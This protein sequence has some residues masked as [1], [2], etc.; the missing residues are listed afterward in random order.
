MELQYEGGAPALEWLQ[1]ILAMKLADQ[2]PYSPVGWSKCGGCGFRD[3]CWQ[4]AE[5]APDVALVYG[6]DQGLARALRDNGARTINELLTTFDQGRLSEFRRPVGRRLQRVGRAAEGILRM[7]Q[8]LISGQEN[9]FGRPDV[10]ECANYVMFDLEGLPPQQDELEKV[11]LWG[12]QVFGERPGEFL[13]ATAGFGDDGDREGWELFLCHAEKIFE[14][15]GDLP[16]VHWHH[17]ERVKLDLYVGR[18]GDREG[19]AQRVIG[20]LLDLLPM[21]RDSV[22]LPV[23]SYSLKVIEKYIGFERTQDE[24]GGDWAIA[25][26]IEATETEDEKLREKTMQDVCLYNKED[27]EATW[28]ILKWLKTKE[29]RGD[30]SPARTT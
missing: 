24:Y 14:D 19:I 5:E 21:T 25:K 13:A 8:A 20:N 26:Y 17:Y 9:V 2:E 29:P 7:A 23:P 18:F 10:P 16:F 15:H 30:S 11:Y 28:E 22:A 1:A 27:L 4:K 3:R 6:V 12:L